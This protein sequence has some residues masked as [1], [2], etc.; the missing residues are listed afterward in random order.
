MARL[1]Y[2]PASDTSNIIAV[3]DILPALKREDS[4]VGQRAGPA[5]PLATSGLPDGVWRGGT[6]FVRTTWAYE[7]CRVFGVHSDAV[8]PCRVHPLRLGETAGMPRSPL[9]ERP[10]TGR[11]IGLPAL[12]LVRDGEAFSSSRKT[13]RVFRTTTVGRDNRARVAFCLP[14]RH[15]LGDALSGTV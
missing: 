4:S 3:F 8:S 2:S 1:A 14:C 15:S 10:G 6:G 5:S 7:G 9:S 12:R 13:H 11:A